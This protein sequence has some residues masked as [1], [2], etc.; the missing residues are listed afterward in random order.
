MD[1]DHQMN[2]NQPSSPL[3]GTSRL[4]RNYTTCAMVIA[5]MILSN[6]FEFHGWAVPPH[7]YLLATNLDNSAGPLNNSYFYTVY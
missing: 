1:I 7:L 2:V 3:Q 4:T 6:W 5:F